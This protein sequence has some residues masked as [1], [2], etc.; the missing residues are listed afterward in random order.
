MSHGQVM[1][2]NKAVLVLSGFL[3]DYRISVQED[4]AGLIF[5]FYFLNF[6]W[7]VYMIGGYTLNLTFERNYQEIRRMSS[8]FLSEVDYFIEL[9]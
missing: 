7:N 8:N 5:K 1:Q 2:P 4:I 9:H 3:R 6:F